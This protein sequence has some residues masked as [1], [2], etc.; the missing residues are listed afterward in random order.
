MGCC[1]WKRSA[2]RMTVAAPAPALGDSRVHGRLDRAEADLVAATHG[3]APLCR[4]DGHRGLAT[5]KHAEGRVSAGRRSVRCSSAASGALI[6]RPSPRGHPRCRVVGG[7]GGA[8]T[9]DRGVAWSAYRDG[10]VEELRALLAEPP[11]AGGG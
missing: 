9:V 3:G 10:G 6:G 1:G 5:I 2:H 4:T 11:P 7:R 8:R